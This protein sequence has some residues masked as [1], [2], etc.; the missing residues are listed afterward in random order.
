MKKPVKKEVKKTR[1]LEYQLNS[2]EKKELSGIALGIAGQIQRL[3]N[4]GKI[5][6]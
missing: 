2:T 5:N 4:K 3:V 6:Q 1:Y